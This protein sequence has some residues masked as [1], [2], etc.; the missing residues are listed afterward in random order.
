MT[1]P[2]VLLGAT[3]QFADACNAMTVVDAGAPVPAGNA[4][5]YA[6]PPADSDSDTVTDTTHPPARCTDVSCTHTRDAVPVAPQPDG[7]TSGGGASGARS[8]NK[9]RYAEIEDTGVEHPYGVCGV[10][11]AAAAAAF[12]AAVDPPLPHG[13]STRGAAVLSA[14]Q[15]TVPHGSTQSTHMEAATAPGHTRARHT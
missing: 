1:P 4:A 10:A 6:A 7:S 2:L 9:I 8:T 5:Q 13:L 15:A 11:A 3:A 12:A 14:G